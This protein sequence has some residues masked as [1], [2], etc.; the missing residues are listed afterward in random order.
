MRTMQPHA[1]R[2]ER[3]ARDAAR[4]GRSRSIFLLVFGGIYGGYFTP[5][6]GAAVGAA[7]TLV[8][9]ARCAAS[10]TGRSSSNAS[11]PTAK[12]RR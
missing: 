1:P 9:R 10:S 2:A 7:A 4:P 3:L 11:L 12:R 5:T 8:A 6:E